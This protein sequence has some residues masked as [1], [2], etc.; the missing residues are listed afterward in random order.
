MDHQSASF[1]DTA[2]KKEGSRV[3]SDSVADDPADDI[4]PSFYLTIEQ[5]RSRTSFPFMIFPED[6]FRLGWDMAVLVIIF[7]ECPGPT[8][9]GL[10]VQQPPCLVCNDAQLPR[11]AFPH[12]SLSLPPSPA[13][14]HITRHALE[15]GLV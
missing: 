6:P 14:R 3:R 10:L 5:A 4:A 7:C 9:T 15:T 12:T 13:V 2:Q 1:V 11:T 8:P